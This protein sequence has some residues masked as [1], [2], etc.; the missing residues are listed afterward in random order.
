MDGKYKR[1]G[2]NTILVFIG[3]LGSGLIT[4][5]M[6][7][8]YTRW[9]GPDQFGLADL[10]NTYSNILVSLVTCSMADAIF[11][12][13][14]TA[15][16][17]GQ[18]KYYSSGLLVAIIGILLSVI[19]ANIL[20]NNC[21]SDL[22]TIHTNSIQI[23]ILSS[24]LFLQSYTQQFT[25]SIDKMKV[26]SISGIVL[27]AAIAVFAFLLIPLFG[28]DGYI[29]SLALANITASLYS[30][31]ASGS[32]KYLSLRFFDKTFAIDLLKYGVPLIPNSIMWWLVDGINRPIMEV[33]LGLS[34]IGIYAVASKFPSVL[35]VI[36]G[37]FSN[38]WGISVSEEYGKDNFNEYFNEIFKLIFFILMVLSMIISIFSDVIISLFASSE[39]AEASSILP[40]LLLGVIFSNS[41]ALFG[42]IFMARKQSKFYFY[43][44]IW[45]SV[46]S[47]L[48]L[49]LFIGL[50]GIYGVALSTVVSIC[51]MSIA[52]AFYVW[53]DINQINIIY[54]LL[55]II[56]YLI[57]LLIHFLLG[58]VPRNAFLALLL[59]IYLLINKQIVFKFLA[60]L[61]KT[62]LVSD[63]NQR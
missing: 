37:A 21:F 33:K 30:F 24:C 35:N 52:R 45:G 34:A 25:R 49:L 10:I 58:G 48:S 13:P 53:R 20:R 56:L 60:V 63:K 44:S 28:A 2:I 39:Y 62:S 5:L 4:F 15:D 26:Y 29:Y 3:K 51:V 9:L 36:S 6:L 22:G 38:A 32:L 1:L 61:K 46:A 8:L 11:I 57:F 55:S 18:C 42:G 23:V 14:K 43:S 41:S 31:F 40:V 12:F 17:N 7:P 27:S 47:L 19:I 54:F 50:F 59:F 16:E